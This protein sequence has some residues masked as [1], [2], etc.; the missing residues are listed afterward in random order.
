MSPAAVP[1]P[2]A[3]TAADERSII[4]TID[5]VGFFADRGDWDR[6]AAQFH[7]GGVTLDYR[8]HASASAGTGSEPARQSP[9]SAVEAWQTVLPGYDHTQH[10]ISNHQVEMGGDAATVLSTIHAMHV[11]GGDSWVFLGDYEHRLVRTDEGWR[12]VRMTANMRAELG[13]PELPRRAAERVARGEGRRNGAQ[14]DGER[15]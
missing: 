12:I 1:S 9:R 8:S 10:A 4:A 13:D 3:A 2:D 5:A 11:L 15:A 6:V 7:P 14:G